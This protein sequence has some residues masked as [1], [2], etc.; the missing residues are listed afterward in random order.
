MDRKQRD[1]EIHYP[2]PNQLVIMKK[3]LLLWCLAVAA[4]ILISCASIATRT[5]HFA[6]IESHIKQHDFITA[7][8]ELETSKNRYYQ[9][10]DRVLY[11]L[12]VG[13]LYHYSGDYEKS[14]QYLTEAENAIDDLF[15][16]SISRA[17]ASLLLNDNVLDYAGEDYEDIYINIFKAINFLHLAEFDKALVE[18]RRINDKLNVLEDKYRELANSYQQAD[19]A[20]VNFT[21]GS[22]RFHNSILGRYLS[23]LLY[24]TEGRK[25]AVRIDYNYILDGWNQQSHIYNFSR[26]DFSSQIDMTSKARINFLSFTGRAPVKK[27][28]DRR[29]TTFDNFLI[30]SGNTPEPFADTIPWPGLNKDYHFKFSI[31][32]ME[33]R[34]SQITQVRVLI[35]DNRVAVLEKIEDIGNVAVETFSVK[36][37]LLYLKSVTR[38]VVKGLLAESAKS[39][40]ESRTDSIGSFLFRVATDI[41]VDISENADLRATRFFP[42]EALIGEVEVDP[43]I[44]DIRVDYYNRYGTMI[45]QDKFDNFEVKR[46]QLNLVHS[47]YLN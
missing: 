18:I 13:M 16:R 20:K 25:D 36:A 34:Y 7:A 11:Y 23:M 44:Y 29:I 3:G 28:H 10:K 1:S 42:G 40:V 46:N 26:P 39:K 17:A 6:T 45:F 47:F 24:R 35:N 4:L 31:P 37:P 41:A 27:A 30:V 43:G 21:A 2:F 14:N 19:E 15:T 5:T 9:A 32:F 22:S 33:R 8:R 12:D 38:S